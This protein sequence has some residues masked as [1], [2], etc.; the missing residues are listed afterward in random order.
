MK[1]KDIVAWLGKTDEFNKKLSN[2]ID[3]HG[4]RIHDLEFSENKE[5]K[6]NGSDIY[7]LK[8]RL[9]SRINKEI[10]LEQQVERLLESDQILRD[11]IVEL[12]KSK[13]HFELLLE[14]LDLEIKDQP[15]KIIAKK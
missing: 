3:E 8:S 14:Y 7:D 11:K 12:E 13:H 6:K 9:K 2:R 1:I 10:L 4:K 15:C 5:A